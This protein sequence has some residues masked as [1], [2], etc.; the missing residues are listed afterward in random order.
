MKTKTKKKSAR[1]RITFKK[2]K[3][4]GCHQDY[5]IYYRGIHIGNVRAGFRHR[6]GWDWTA[7]TDINGREILLS[8]KPGHS[9]VR[10]A[11]DLLDCMKALGF[12]KS[13]EFSVPFMETTKDVGWDEK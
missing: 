6:A 4:E 9:R 10:L 3:H 12:S 5:R 7:R 1:A 2:V 11:Q 13:K 8:G